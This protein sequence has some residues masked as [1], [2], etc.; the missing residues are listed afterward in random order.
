MTGLP[1]KFAGF[2]IRA[3]AALVDSVALGIP[4][5]LV[6][7]ILYFLMSA[8]GME[9]AA[10]EMVGQ[11]ATT[12]IAIGYYV[13]FHS[14]KYQ[15]TLGKLVLGIHLMRR[16][17]GA[18][19]PKLALWRYI[20]LILSAIPLGLGFLMAGWTREKTALH[21]L[22]CSTRVVYGRAS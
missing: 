6:G 5:A 14:S 2:W 16:D 20:A 8:F 3:A 22:V 17:G 15:A 12:L 1:Y 11:I 10:V 7:I 13:G 4:S 21:D 9:E 19:T 18:I